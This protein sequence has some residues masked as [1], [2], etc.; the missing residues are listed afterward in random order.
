MN[1]ITVHDVEDGV[2]ITINVN[3][4]EAM[5]GTDYGTTISTVNGILDTVVIIGAS[6]S[7]SSTF[8][9][10][11]SIPDFN[12]SSTAADSAS[13]INGFDTTILVMV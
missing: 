13:S 1:F 12:T 8:G 7:N 6:F 11:A 2:E 4:I 3:L 9:P 10:C 5:C